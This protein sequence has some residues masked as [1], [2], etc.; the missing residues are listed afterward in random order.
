MLALVPHGEQR[1]L[2]GGWGLGL[3]LRLGVGCGGWGLGWGLGWVLGVAVTLALSQCWWNADHTAASR[4][5]CAA[6]PACSRWY[7]PSGTEA[8]W[9]EVSTMLK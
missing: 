8:L 3:G 6:Q 7:S 5:T 4:R 2:G 1:H 9:E